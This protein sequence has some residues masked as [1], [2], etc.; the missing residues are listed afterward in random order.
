MGEAAWLWRTGG[1]GFDLVPTVANG[2][3]PDE[4]DMKDDGRE[5]TN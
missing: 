5:G 2:V 3:K 4:R 1:W